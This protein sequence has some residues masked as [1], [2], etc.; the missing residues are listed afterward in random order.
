MPGQSKSAV[1]LRLN[2]LDLHQPAQRGTEYRLT[3]H[4]YGLHGAA[5][6]ADRRHKL[7]PDRKCQRGNELIREF[8]HGPSAYSHI[9]VT[10]PLGRRG[11]RSTAGS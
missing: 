8:L 3:G 11:T 2:D 4:D 1:S 10:R 5:R 6:H 9:G 7:D